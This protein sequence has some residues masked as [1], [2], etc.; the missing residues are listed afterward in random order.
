MESKELNNYELKEL[1]RDLEDLN[2]D[3]KDMKTIYSST[4]KTCEMLLANMKYFCTEEWADF[5]EEQKKDFGENV[6]NK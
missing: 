3:I 4:I 5:T 2:R 6:W 1:V